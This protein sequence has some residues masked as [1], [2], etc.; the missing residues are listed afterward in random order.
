MPNEEAKAQ[1]GW[2]ICL[3]LHRKE[4]TRISLDVWIPGP[5]FCFHCICTLHCFSL[6]LPSALQLAVFL[7]QR[8][9]ELEPEDIIANWTPFYHRSQARARP[10]NA[11]ALQEALALN[12]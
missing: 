6:D 5:V 11:E 8:L 7:F 1:K 2:N 12:L 9:D 4:W 3:R 10:L